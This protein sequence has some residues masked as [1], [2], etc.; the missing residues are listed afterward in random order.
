MA[1]LGTAAASEPGGPALK[2][3]SPRK[4]KY[5][6]ARVKRSS[7][8]CSLGFLR[9]ISR[10]RPWAD[11]GQQQRQ[12]Q[13]WS[14]GTLDQGK[15]WL[16]QLLTDVVRLLGLFY[17]GKKKTETGF[18]IIT[19]IHEQIFL[20]GKLHVQMM[21]ESRLLPLGTKGIYGK[22]LLQEESASV[23]TSPPASS[24]PPLSWVHSAWSLGVFLIQ[25]A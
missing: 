1:Q 17:L 22:M 9:E 5:F 7:F 12:P 14:F 3:G 10:G 8:L 6:T 23:G 2:N 20:K 18:P 15:D 16:W 4:S 13:G 19:E 25:E 21:Q 24:F 11:H